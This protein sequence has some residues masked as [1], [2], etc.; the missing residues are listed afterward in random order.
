VSLG[1][2]ATSQSPTRPRSAYEDL[3]MLS[4][5]LNQ[6]RVNHP[7]STDMHALVMAAIQGIVHQADPHSYVIPYVR[8]NPE[9]EQAARDGKLFFVPID[10]AFYGGSPVVVRIAPG[11]A[12]AR[13]DIIPGDELI[14]I[15][16]QSFV[17]QGS[18][19]LDITLAGAKKVP[20][21]LTLERRR[22][23]GSLLQF[24]RDVKRERVD[25]R[26]AVP[27]VFMLDAK[28]GYVRITTFVGEKV[29]DDLHDALGRLEKQGME[30]LVLDLRDNG[31]GSVAEAA[32]VAG[33]FLPKGAVVYTAE[34]RKADV[35][36]TGRVK[37]SFWRNEKRYPLV[38]MVNSGTASASELVA[39]AL[40]DHDRAVVVGRPSFGKSLLMQGFPLPD[41][42]V[43]VMVIGHIKTPCGRVVQR[44]YR[45]ISRRDYYRLA[46]VERDTAGR[47]SCKTDGGRIAYGGGG[48]YPDVLL[49]DDHIQPLW[50]ARIGEEALAFKWTP[51]YLTANPAAFPSLDQLAAHPVL[52]A[53]ALGSFRAFAAQQDVTIPSG[54]DADKL[55]ER[56]LLER[57]ADAKWSDEGHYRISAI[58]DRDVAAAIASFV[59][60]QAIL[61]RSKTQ[62]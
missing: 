38:V 27:T 62:D 42:S 11:S 39:G 19:E 18:E 20:V 10:F 59:Q 46:R 54:D 2:Q 30:R 25:E 23:D 49:A 7:D 48:I 21:V 22:A 1:A 61:A 37:R 32:R 52:P 51:G 9:K 34:G 35:T 29:A 12:A 50:L 16:K 55:L 58:L 17:A 47:P 57:I 5:V 40:Q 13:L 36:D 28:T 44:Q 4:G 3:Q 53:G 6:I 56:A 26:T 15:D 45:S 24:D 8:L 14:A 33:E 31:G 43:F 60:A 41:G